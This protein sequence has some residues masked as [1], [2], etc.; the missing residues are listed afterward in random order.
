MKRQQTLEL[1]IKLLTE[2]AGPERSGHSITI[3]MDFQ[4]NQIKTPVNYFKQCFLTA[5]LLRTLK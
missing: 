3:P 2:K 5:K 1:Y 4:I